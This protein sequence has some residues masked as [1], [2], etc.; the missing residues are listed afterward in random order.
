MKS[1]RFICQT[2]VIA[3]LYVVLTVVFM[4]I[5]FGAIQCRISEALCLL[6][7]LMPAAVYG[8]TLGCFIANIVGGAL[9]WDVVFGTLSTFTGAFFTWHLT[10]TFRESLARFLDE[11][12]SGNALDSSGGAESKSEKV[13]SLPL[14][15]RLKSA[16]PPVISNSIIV[17][18]VLKYAYMLDDAYLVLCFTV[19]VGEIISAGILGN[20]LLSALCRKN[21][22]MELRK[23]SVL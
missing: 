18:L 15:I 23:L 4:P 7:V 2:A 1:V 5:S 13:L 11:T 8:V 17:P 16:L 19:G 10:A 14:S 21:I 12:S 22:L 20:I 6:P 9:I 3:S